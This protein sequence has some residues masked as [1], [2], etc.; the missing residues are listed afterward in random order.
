[1][2]A[3]RS[4]AEAPGDAGLASPADVP[5]DGALDG[6]LAWENSA[7][8]KTASAAS[9]SAMRSPALTVWFVGEFTQKPMYHGA[10]ASL[11]MR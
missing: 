10:S 2:T 9:A 11:R 8:A 4:L 1:M 5:L 3:E 6:P 7:T